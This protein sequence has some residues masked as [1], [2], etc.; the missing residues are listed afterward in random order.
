MC[1]LTRHRNPEAVTLGRH[2]AAI[3]KDRHPHHDRDSEPLQHGERD[4]IP[5]CRQW[6]IVDRSDG[7][8]GDGRVLPVESCG[9]L[10][11]S[12]IIERRLER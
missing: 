1:G 3:R 4:Q 5:L 8:I 12:R 6:A 2:G 11:H 7:G 10:L 9:I